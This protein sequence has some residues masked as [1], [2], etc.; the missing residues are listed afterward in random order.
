MTFE[1]FQKIMVQEGLTPSQALSLWQTRPT[2]DLDE[3]DLKET[4]RAMKAKGF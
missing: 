4:A 1:K 3:E 2:D